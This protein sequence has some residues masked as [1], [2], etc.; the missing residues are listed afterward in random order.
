MFEFLKNCL[1][2]AKE[3]K[4]FYIKH[5]SLWLLSC[6]AKTLQSTI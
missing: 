1:K 2:A 5:Y 3:L 4:L 6:L